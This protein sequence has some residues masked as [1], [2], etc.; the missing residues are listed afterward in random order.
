[1]TIMNMNK[2][3]VRTAIAVAMGT[4]GMAA[5]PMASAV[6]TD[7]SILSF[8]AAASGTVQP[9]VGTG[10]WFSMKISTNTTAFTGISSNDGVILGTAQGAT[11]SHDGLPGCTPNSK[12][13][14]SLPLAENP[15]IDNAWGFFGNT[16][17]HQT[18]SAASVTA[19]SGSTGNVD[20]SGWSV[21]WNGIANIPMSGGAFGSTSVYTSGI[22]NV[23]CAVDCNNGDS[24][25]LN[26]RATVPAG[27]PSGFGGVNYQV[28][29]EGTIA[30]VPVPAAVWLFGSGLVGLVGV[31]RRKKVSV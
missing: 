5:A 21:T 4:A 19:A 25:T 16:G 10:S 8:S 17:F 2:K 30:A 15:G 14:N 9:V 27:D 20:F 7:G 3:L 13:N 31:A 18:T 11:G 22:A 12:C 26:Y 28:H 24:Y 29:L 23:S 6:L 1:M